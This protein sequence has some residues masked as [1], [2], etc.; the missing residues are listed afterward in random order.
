[1]GLAAEVER[2]RAQNAELAAQNIELAA[3]NIELAAQNIELAA[4]NA[5]LAAKLE[6]LEAELEKLR[7]DQGRNSSNSGKP[8]SSDTL[9]E[10]AKQ[11]EERLSRAERRRLAREKAKKYLNE[12]V[13][14]RPG[15]QPGTAGAGLAKVPEP[16][17]TVLHV[18][19]RC[20][21]CGDS[22]EGA[23][24]TGAE[25]RQVHDLPRQGLEVTEHQA[26]SRRCHCGATTKAGFP[27]EATAPACYGPVVRATAVYLMAGQHIPV[28]RAAALLSQ[29][30]GAPVS[31]GW[32]AGLSGEA[33]AGL[34][35]FLAELRAQLAAEDVL[36]ADETGS[37]IS[38]ARYWFHVACTGLLTL[39][40]CHP[41]RGVEAFADMA[42]LPLFS[43]VLVSDGW[44]PYWSIDGIEH[45]LCCA[46]LLRDLAGLTGSPKHRQW[47][48]D[49]ADLLVEVK[50][51]LEEVLAAGKEALSAGQLR[52][53]RARYTKLL[54]RGLA[55]LPARHNPGSVHR[56]AYNLLCRLRDQR[57]EVTRYWYDPR[58]G[59]TNNQAERDVRMAKLQQKISGCFRTFAAAKAFCA[60]RSYLQTAQKHGL[61]AMEVLVQLFKGNPWLPPRAI[62]PP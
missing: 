13:R 52:A 59:F 36:H 5:E 7:R 58:V 38:G 48:D 51:A 28:A 62:S 16:D 37:R 44:K 21:R 9:T 50:N 34:S 31:T 60:V 17:W 18:P 11:G 35:P 27:P 55:A 57:H 1:V 26:Q 54:N 46:H 43:G 47:A 14:R 61:Q 56:D 32:L 40:D 45:A 20:W 12:R 15:K 10:R 19:D 25:V 53:Y 3:Q 6:A 42:V 49:M 24:V 23:Q 2:L 29:V 4:K 39:L 30:C 33:A 8:P 41:R 22:L